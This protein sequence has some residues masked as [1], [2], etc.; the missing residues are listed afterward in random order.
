VGSAR[1]GGS[2]IETKRRRYA[3]TASE[4]FGIVVFV[5]LAGAFA[6]GW[7]GRGT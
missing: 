2:T 7:P 4:L 6:A 3:M 1:G 5:L